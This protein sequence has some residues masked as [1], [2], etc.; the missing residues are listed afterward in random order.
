MHPLKGNSSRKMCNGMENACDIMLTK[1][2][3]P[4]MHLKSGLK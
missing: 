4:K 2:A 1:K 3:D